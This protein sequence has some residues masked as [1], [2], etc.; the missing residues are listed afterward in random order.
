MSA[1]F[2]STCSIQTAAASSSSSGIYLEAAAVVASSAN[3]SHLSPVR[4]SLF[5]RRFSTPVIHSLTFSIKQF[6][7]QFLSHSYFLKNVGAHDL[8]ASPI[9]PFTWKGG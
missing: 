4:V 3:F 6:T 9:L 7:I 2:S 1:S 5:W 8:A